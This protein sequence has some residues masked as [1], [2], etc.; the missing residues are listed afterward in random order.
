MIALSSSSPPLLLLT[1]GWEEE[2]EMAKEDG[3]R[4]GMVVQGLGCGDGG[5]DRF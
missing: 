2:E 1:K 4:T 5:F 3:E